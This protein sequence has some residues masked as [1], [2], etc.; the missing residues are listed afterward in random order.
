LRAEGQEGKVKSE[1]REKQIPLH[2]IEQRTL[3]GDP[4]F[5]NDN[6]KGNNKGTPPCPAMKLPVV[7]GAPAFREWDSHGVDV[8]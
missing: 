4:A 6:Q 8:K 3:V 7:D 1:R 2:P 5:E